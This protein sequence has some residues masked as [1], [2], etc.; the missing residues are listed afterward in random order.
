MPERRKD[1]QARVEFA[2][3][4]SERAYSAWCFNPTDEN[5][6]AWKVAQGKYMAAQQDAEPLMLGG[7]A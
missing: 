3:Q 6:A 2:K 5:R 1:P 7:V 4:E